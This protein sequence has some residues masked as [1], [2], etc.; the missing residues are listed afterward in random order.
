MTGG[1]GFVAAAPVSKCSAMITAI[2]GFS[3]LLQRDLATFF[4][5]GDGEFPKFGEVPLKVPE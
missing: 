2:T 3:V 1:G 5:G 4:E